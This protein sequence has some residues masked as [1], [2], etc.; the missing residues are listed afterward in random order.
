MPDHHAPIHTVIA[1]QASDNVC[2]RDVHG[3]SDGCR[4]QRIQHL[5]RPQ[6]WESQLIRRVVEHDGTQHPFQAAVR[7]HPA[8]YVGLRPL[9][10]SEQPSGCVLPQGEGARIIG[11]DNCH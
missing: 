5:M 3:H 8:A 1:L 2:G 4:G 10:K 6:Y 7:P 9:A 11:V